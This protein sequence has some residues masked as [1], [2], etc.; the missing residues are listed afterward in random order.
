MRI[1]Y[2]NKGE[3]ILRSRQVDYNQETFKLSY[4]HRQD[5]YVL[6]IIDSFGL[7]ANSASFFEQGIKSEGITFEEM[8]LMNHPY[9]P[10]V[11]MTYIP[12]GYREFNVYKF[13]NP[14]GSGGGNVQEDIQVNGVNLANYATLADFMSAAGSFSDTYSP[15]HFA[16]QSI[17]HAAGG[18]FHYAYADLA[19]NF[20]LQGPRGSVWQWRFDD[21]VNFVFVPK[22][23]NGDPYTFD[24]GSRKAFKMV[25][26]LTVDMGTTNLNIGS[27]RSTKTDTLATSGTFSFNS[28]G[29]IRITRNDDD[30]IVPIT[31]EIIDDPT[32]IT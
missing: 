5:H 13:F 21:G 1:I 22:D 17:S 8:Y 2:V 24:T 32:I 18:T 28:E 14:F 9:M 11:G 25:R 29:K 26:D 4:T 3:D 7:V 12:G 20:A 31:I 27:I 23:E 16:I 15:R 6:Q 10:R 30:S 19:G